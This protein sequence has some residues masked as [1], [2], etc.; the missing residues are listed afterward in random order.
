MWVPLHRRPSF[1][2]NR[3]RRRVEQQPQEVSPFLDEPVTDHLKEENVEINGLEIGHSSMQGYRV[4]MEDEHIIDRIESV[5]DHTIV[6]VMDG[7][8]GAFSAIFTSRE[9]KNILEQTE[10]WKEYAL[11]KPKERDDS[12]ELISQALVE[13]YVE[14]DKCL[15]DLDKN[16]LMDQSGCT[17][18][19]AVITPT[20]VI[21]ANVGDSRAVVGSTTTGATVSLTEDHKPNLPEEKARIE[22][23]GGFVA[24]DR[25]NGELAMSRAL[26]D[27]RYKRNQDLQA[28][29][30]PVICYPDV[31]VHRRSGKKDEVLVLA[32]DGVF[33]VMSNS[34][35]TDYI[36]E[37][38]LKDEN[39]TPSTEVN[40]QI[41]SKNGSDKNGNNSNKN[42]GNN[43][44]NGSKNGSVNGQ[45][46]PVALSTVTAQEAAGSLIDLALA[47]ES[48]DNISAV[49]VK[50]L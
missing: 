12:L 39:S 16:G 42:S 1:A 46:E 27:F 32:C 19:C 22:K 21:C 28:H 41:N 49:I 10:K 23:G 18:V 11:L 7:H 13:T 36:C 14:I 29:E 26:G 4:S 47:E 3:K 2:F 20:H 43:K 48:T 30:F 24:M 9:L 17:C 31:A 40:V 44:K 45:K 5:P 33:D 37:V 38:V 50:F 35:V 6:A 8:A 25:V 15:L 34:E